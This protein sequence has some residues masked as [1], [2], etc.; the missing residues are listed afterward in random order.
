MRIFLTLFLIALISG[1]GVDVSSS[2]G[3]NNSQVK[4]SNTS[5]DTNVSTD[6]NTTD[7]NAT[8]DS[9]ETKD[10]NTTTSKLLYEASGD[11]QYDPNAC[12]SGYATAVPLQD[13]NSNE[14]P[15]ESDDNAN[16]ISLMS[17]Y[18]QTLNPD[19]S[20]VIAFYKKIPTGL[21]VGDATQRENVYGDNSQFVLMYDPLWKSLQDNVVYVQTPTLGDNLPKCYRI[22]I[23][24]TATNLIVPQQVYRYQN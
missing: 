16:G 4:D 1:C 20:L 23:E 17:L 13:Y 11:A 3:S 5:V 9:N 24:D 22:T 2:S 12:Y 7:S 18:T 8:V 21:S 10:T 15:R 14:S 6:N 19:D